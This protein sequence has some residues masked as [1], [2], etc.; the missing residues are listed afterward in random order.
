MADDGSYAWEKLYLANRNLAAGTGPLKQRLRDAFIPHLMTVVPHRDLL[1]DDL[2][3]R[4]EALMED[5]APNNRVDVALEEWS[6][7]DL[8]R[9]AQEIADIYDTVARRVAE[10]RTRDA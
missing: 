1:W 8:I 6:E 5:L 7:F 9:I 3:Q 4:F 10:K 2:R